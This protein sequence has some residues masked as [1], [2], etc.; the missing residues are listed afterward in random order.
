MALIRDYE[1]AE[2]GLTVPNAYFVIDHISL[3]KRK[4]DENLPMDP[5]HPSGFTDGNDRSNIPEFLWKAGWHCTFTMVVYASS[6]ARNDETKNPI[7]YFSARPSSNSPDDTN[8]DNIYNSILQNLTFS[9]DE[10]AGT[11][12]F[13][14]AYDHLRNNVDY[15]SDATSDE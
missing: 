12:C 11:S 14:Q 13:K 10:A 5:N 2:L 15:F 1:V 6:E 3:S 7:G 8:P 4:F 9:Y